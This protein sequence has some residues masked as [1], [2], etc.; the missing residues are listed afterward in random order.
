MEVRL[1]EVGGDDVVVALAVEVA[2]SMASEGGCDGEAG[3]V[4][5]IFIVVSST[6]FVLYPFSL[7][8]Y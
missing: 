5:I 2:P 1:P 7:M 6:I 8:I 4:S 3:G